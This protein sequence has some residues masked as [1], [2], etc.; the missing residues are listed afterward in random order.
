MLFLSHENMH[1]AEEVMCFQFIFSGLVM[2]GA[3]NC[4]CY[5]RGW[6]VKTSSCSFLYCSRYLAF[7]W[8]EI[9][10]ERNVSN[11]KDTSFSVCAYRCWGALLHVWK[12]PS[13]S[14]ER[15]AWSL[16]NPQVM[17]VLS[18]WGKMLIRPFCE[19]K[20]QR[21]WWQDRCF[22]MEGGKQSIKDCTSYST[23][24]S[25]TCL[26]HICLYFCPPQHP[27]LF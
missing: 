24:V 22:H 13:P 5:A 27:T 6:T 4:D 21:F 20:Q 3:S 26:L 17:S 25:C 23:S 15:A 7:W 16:I 10:I 2:T 1:V 19:W 8:I 12:K 9:K 14:P 11:L 18:Q